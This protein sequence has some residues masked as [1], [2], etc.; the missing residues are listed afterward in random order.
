[1]RLRAG[2]DRSE[3]AGPGAR[4]IRARTRT[5]AFA[6]CANISAFVVAGNA[7]L[8]SNPY[9]AVRRQC[10]PGTLVPR[11]HASTHAASREARSSSAC[12]THAS[13]T[14]L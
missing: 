9:A 2:M 7:S 11:C 5:W 1:M 4:R 3:D 8:C 13:L 10:E 14:L 12:P 6:T